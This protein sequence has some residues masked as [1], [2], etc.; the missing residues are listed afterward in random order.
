MVATAVV[1]LI[2][3][4]AGSDASVVPSRFAGSYTGI[5]VNKTNS[6]DRGTSEWFIDGQGNVAG[7]DFD[8]TL[9]ITYTVVGHVDED[10]RLSTTATPDNGTAPATLSGNVVVN[11]VGQVAGDLTWGV[12]PPLSYN[13]LLTRRE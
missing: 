4:C 11:A 9:D 10:G 2:A 1:L 5:W 13:Y 8:P 7:E 3:G 6:D 12:D